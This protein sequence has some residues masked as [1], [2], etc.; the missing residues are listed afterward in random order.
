MLMDALEKVYSLG[1]D[2]ALA[3][4]AQVPDTISLD[5]LSIHMKLEHDASLAHVDAYYG[6]DPMLADDALAQDL[7][8]R[9]GNDR[10]LTNL[11]VAVTRKDRDN[12]C[13]KKN[14]DCSYDTRGDTIAFL[15]AALLLMVLGTGDTISVS[16]R[17]R[18]F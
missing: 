2:L 13:Y 17:A 3:L 5:Y 12:T 15:E 1:P 7:F 9:A 11:I 4:V 16:T 14:P 6:K 8:N 10:L 18:S